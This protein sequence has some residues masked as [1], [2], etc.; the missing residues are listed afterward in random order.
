MPARSV[1]PDEEGFEVEAL[2][3][4]SLGVGSTVGWSM[5]RHGPLRLEKIRHRSA[6]LDVAVAAPR[7]PSTQNFPM[8]T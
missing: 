5:L 8:V 1:S 4:S 6:G 7:L 3:F 2:G